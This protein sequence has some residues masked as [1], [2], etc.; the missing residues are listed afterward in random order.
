MTGPVWAHG[1]YDRSINFLRRGGGNYRSFYL[2]GGG[3]FT[4]RFFKEGRGGGGF[5]ARFFKEGGGNYRSIF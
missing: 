2:G 4:V 5:T 1:H 3:G